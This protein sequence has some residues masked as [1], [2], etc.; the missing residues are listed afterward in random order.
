MQKHRAMQKEKRIWDDILTDRDKIVYETTGFGKRV[1]LGTRPAI[2]II[3]VNYEF[4][5]DKPKPI[6]ESIKKFPLSCGESGWKSVEKIR[7]LLK[8]GRIKGIPVFYSIPEFRLE[9]AN[10][11]ATKSERKKEEFSVTMPE[12][13]KIV[14]EIAPAADDIVIYKQRASVFFGTPL[15][16]HLTRFSVDTLL[17]CGTTTSGCVRASVVDAF[18]YGLRVAVIEECTFDRGEVS[19]KV[20]L[21]DMHQKYANV[22]SLD[23]TLAYL[24]NI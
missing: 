20:N 24:D 19:H 10:V 11:G 12:I 4:V 18:S 9:T 15:I 21:F 7:L 1:E 2:L 16:S 22:I 14:K 13:K 17:V 8:R 6:L 3:D 5:G 23:E